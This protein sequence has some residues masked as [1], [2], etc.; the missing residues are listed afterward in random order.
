MQI[1][2]VCRILEI[3]PHVLRYWEKE[4]PEV[5]PKKDKAGNRIYSPG[6]VQL[7]LRIKHFLY[8]KRFT[9][10]GARQEILS[11]LGEIDLDFRAS[12]A[13]LR[14]SLLSIYSITRKNTKSAEKKA[15]E[16]K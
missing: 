7:L 12:V 16:R 9:I 3:K 13:A 14:D 8:S 4:I 2:D 10:E 6:D 15:A 1:G 5:S 11:E